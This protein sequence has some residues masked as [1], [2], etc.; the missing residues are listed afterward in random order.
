MSDTPIDELDRAA[1]LTERH[2]QSCVAAVVAQ[3]KPQQTQNPDG[4]WPVTECIT[5]GNDI[6]PERLEMGRIRCT[7]CQSKEEQ[8]RRM[9]AL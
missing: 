4:T 7:I 2:T 6:P 3:L 9:Y 5:C 1:E 8:Q